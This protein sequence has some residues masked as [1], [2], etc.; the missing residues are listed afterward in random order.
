MKIEHYQFGKLTIDGQSYSSDVII[1]PEGV[2]DS[3]W[4]VEGHSLCEKDLNPVFEKDPEVLVIGTGASGRMRVGAEMIE[5]MADRCS[6]VHVE[7]TGKAVQVYNALA[8]GNKRVVAAL[9]LT[10]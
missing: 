2:D 5:Y 10:C 8:G 4:R 3:W 9:H 1:W 7:E 6:E